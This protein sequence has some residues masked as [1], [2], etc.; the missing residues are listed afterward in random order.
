MNRSAFASGVLVWLA[1]AFPFTNAD[2][3]RGRRDSDRDYRSSV[4]TTFAFD[5]RGT[6]ALTIGSGD[7]IVTGWT[8]DQVRIHAVSENDN[9]RLDASPSRVTLELGSSYR[10]RGETRFEIS[11]PVG[12]RVIA[13]AQS[14]DVSIRGTK[15]EVEA[16]SQSGDISLEDASDRIDVNTLSGDVE[17]RGLSG[18]VQLKSVNGDMRITGLNGDLEAESVSGSVVVR[19]AVSRYVRAHTTSGDVGY[20]GTIDS[21]GRYELVTHSGDIAL[22]IPSNAGAQLSISTWSGTIESA[23][24]ITLKPGE[25]GIGSS[26]A[27]RFTFEIGK[28]GARVT[29]ETFSGDINISSLSRQSR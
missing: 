22:G 25:H 8:R 29:A 12:T 24:P 15:G 1:L 5:K 20:E 2:A 19:D 16:R 7:I 10:S 13:R 9:I 28:G 17:A 21:T 14:G 11:V 6:V 3:Q 23:F 4:D 26:Q 18:D 27:K